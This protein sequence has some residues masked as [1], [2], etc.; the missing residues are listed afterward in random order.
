MLSTPICRLQPRGPVS[1][2]RKSL[3]TDRIA[4][5]RTL[6]VAWA[7]LLGYSAASK[8]LDKTLKEEHAAEPKLKTISTPQRLNKRGGLQSTRK[9]P[10]APLRVL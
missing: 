2:S 9:A 6:V 1:A 3:H 7:D 5:L 4:L 10:V 8:I